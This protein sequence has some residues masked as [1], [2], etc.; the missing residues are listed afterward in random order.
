M[1][2]VDWVDRKLSV[3]MGAGDAGLRLPVVPLC[4]VV[5]VAP[6][7]GAGQGAVDQ[8]ADPDD[9]DGADHDQQH[10][11]DGTHHT[12]HEG[13]GRAHAR[14]VAVRPATGFSPPEGGR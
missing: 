4:L 8:V 5:P 14:I 7:R 3:L 2:P 9:Q 6:G 13:R 1:E 10:E 11:T 12:G